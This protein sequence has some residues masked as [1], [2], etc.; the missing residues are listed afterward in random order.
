MIIIL[1]YMC[2]HI[3]LSVV[4]RISI[5]KQ[6]LRNVIKKLTNGHQKTGEI[7]SGII[8]VVERLSEYIWECSLNTSECYSKYCSFL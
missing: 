3:I 4:L 2:M 5:K 6:K 1:N 7:V 8:F